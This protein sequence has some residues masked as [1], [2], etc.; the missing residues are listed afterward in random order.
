VILGADAGP[1][2]LAAIKKHGLKTL[3]ED[4][5]LNLIATRVPDVNDDKLKKKLEK[6]QD[7]IRQ[8]VHEMERRERTAT[9]SDA[10]YNNP[11]ISLP[12]VD[13]TPAQFLY[14]ANCGQIDMPPVH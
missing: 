10:R 5:F 13:N 1:S 12:H 11:L 3:D 14:R 6:E 2:K 9:K 4:G 7:A 8:A